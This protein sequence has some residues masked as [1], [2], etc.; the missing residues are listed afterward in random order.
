M[1]ILNRP[2]FRLGGSTGQGITSGL[3]PRKR[4]AQGS[5]DWDEV[6]AGR[7]KLMKS[8]GPPPRGY[9]VYDFLTDWGL[10]MASATPSGNVLQT[11]AKQAIEPH[12]KLMAGKG[13]QEMAD[14]M[15]GV[16][17]TG[18]SLSAVA[19]VA[20]AKAAHQEKL[21]ERTDERII[22]DVAA[23]I[24]NEANKLYP[25]RLQNIAQTDSG[26][27]GISQGRV[28]A[29]NERAKGH[30]DTANVSSELYVFDN[31]TKTWEFDEQQL[32]TNKIWF[33]VNTKTYLTVTLDK[34]GKKVA[35]YHTTAEEG[36]NYLRT[37]KK[38]EKATPVEDEDKPTEPVKKEKKSW[39]SRNVQPTEEYT[40]N[41][42]DF[43]PKPLADPIKTAEK[44]YE[45]MMTF[46]NWL[47]SPKGNVKKE[48]EKELAKRPEPIR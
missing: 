28:N 39:F 5:I 41:P 21:K 48:V 40:Y 11:G 18:A 44:D 43:M 30:D 13:E 15:A 4:Y 19:D 26:S 2:M 23:Q 27:I 12:Q 36:R 22:L 29:K 3:T 25:G 10:R 34:D 46:W 1:R 9:G 33:D 17:A 16:S 47:S 24:Q 38:S 14:Y 35:N 45:E 37:Y 32:S 42:E 31:D 7:D 8:Y 6:T 20:A